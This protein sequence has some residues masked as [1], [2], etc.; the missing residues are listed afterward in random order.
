MADHNDDDKPVDWKKYIDLDVGEAALAGKLPP[1][2]E[3]DDVIRQ[4]EDLLSLNPPRCIALTGPSGVGKTT[5]LY[6][7][8]HRALSGRGAA[9]LAQ[10][11]VVQISLKRIRSSFQHDFQAAVHA[12]AVFDGLAE[13]GWIPLIR[14]LSLLT[15]YDWEWMLIRF[16][17]QTGLPVIGE[18]DDALLRVS[19]NVYPEFADHL[20]TLEVKQPTGDRLARLVAAWAAHQAAH[21]KVVTSEAQREAVL[22]TSRFLADQ[23]FPKKVFDLLAQARD[24]VRP[25]EDGVI[26]PV[27][28]RDVVVRF[29]ATS[30]VPAALIDP[31]V[32]LDLDDLRAFLDKRLLGQE[33][34]VDAV[35][36]VIALV[37]SGLTDPRRPFG[38]FFFVGPTGVGKTHATQLL[39]EYLFGDASR[40]VR[41]NLNEYASEAA[42][43]ELFGN[44]HGNT[45]DQRRGVLSRRLDGVDFG[46]LLLDEFEKAHSSAHNVFL[47]LFD[48]GVFVNGHGQQVS[49]RSHIIICTANAG[50][51]VYREAGLGFRSAVDNRALDE[52]IDR[53]LRRS[54]SF[55]LLNRFDRIVHFHTLERSHIRAIARR[56]IEVLLQREGARDRGMTVEVEPEVV[57][58]LAGH[59]YHP[60]FGAR[61][62]R[63]TLEREVAGTLADAMVRTGL[64]RGSRFQLSVRSGRV[65][66]RVVEIEEL[67]ASVRL[68]A[69]QPPVQLDAA[70]LQ[71]EVRAWVERQ[72]PLR[73]EHASR[74]EEAS[75]L[76][77]ASQAARFWEDAAGAPAVLQRY[78][79]LDARI[80]TDERLLRPLERAEA[81]LAEG[82]WPPID[83]L[84]RLVEELAGAWSDWTALDSEPDVPS[85]WL[86]ISGLDALGNNAGFVTDLVGM[87][88]AWAP[89]HGL[90]V[91]AVAEEELDG[92]LVGVVLEIDGPGA[93]RVLAM[94]DGSHRRR[95][96]DNAVERARVIVVPRRGGALA[97]GVRVESARKTRGRLVELRRHRLRLD[98]P[99][100]GVALVFLGDG[101]DTMR[102]LGADLAAALSSSAETVVARTYGV[103]GGTVRDPRTDASLATV[104]EAMKGQLEPLLR[105]WLER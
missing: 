97:A 63:R 22:L 47:Q 42:Q 2:W 73:L 78:A 82:R 68:R 96:P 90:R 27:D 46:V 85:V 20:R 83:E 53:R 69:G 28:A 12:D 25:R 15:A 56:E 9:V 67:T 80:Q 48:E 91:E 37:K 79:A 54:F 4:C 51:E 57:E 70:A 52:E 105:A 19:M 66:A 88:R 64:R 5:V 33:E 103:V 29:A 92:E 18:G 32:R 81:W 35:I 39:A 84:G 38:V 11:R 94:E 8:V 58:W 45:T 87:Y 1:A 10:H 62:L 6:E 100:R 60:L 50:A 55:E 104:K 23:P 24:L 72:A 77:A 26:R 95:G 21:G 14:D 75:A 44:P 76:I 49:L 34:A 93:L 16:A 13:E 89:R 74:K 40:V 41:L 98:L 31:N 7:L 59:G 71:A 3:V 61:F 99:T 30:H 43:W 86:Y 17:S 102:A 101:E 65:V 36:R